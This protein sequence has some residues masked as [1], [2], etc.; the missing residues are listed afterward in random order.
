MKDETSE[1]KRGLKREILQSLFVGLWIGLWARYAGRWW[2]GAGSLLVLTYAWLRWGRLVVRGQ[3]VGVYRSL[4]PIPVRLGRWTRD[5]SAPSLP[6]RTPPYMRRYRWLL[7]AVW[8]ALRGLPMLLLLCAPA[9]ASP[10]WTA[11]GYDAPYSTVAALHEPWVASVH[12]PGRSAH[13]PA[14]TW[15]WW[16]AGLA[17]LLVLTGSYA[18]LRWGGGVLR[19]RGA[20]VACDPSGLWLTAHPESYPQRHT[21]H[22]WLP[23]A[24]RAA[25]AA[26]RERR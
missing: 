13:S 11:S 17:P 14:P 23:G 4:V 3:R 20:D 25:L 9:L 5:P 19:V 12:A 24:L 7:G 10:S 22:R 16:A 21:W 2:W 26:L 18:R 6:G 8:A 15:P 1:G